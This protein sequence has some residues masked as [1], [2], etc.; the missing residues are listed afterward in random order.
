MVLREVRAVESVVEPCRLCV[1]DLADG[2]R[3]GRRDLLLLVFDGSNLQASVLRSEE[4]FVTV[5]TEE[6]IRRVLTSC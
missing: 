2:T 5:E 4:N 3:L 6:C 1:G